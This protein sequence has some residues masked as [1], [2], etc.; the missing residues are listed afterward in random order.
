MS[1]WQWRNDGMTW[2]GRCTHEALASCFMIWFVIS[3]SIPVAQRYPF[4]VHTVPQYPYLCHSCLYPQQRIQVYLRPG[5]GRG[6]AISDHNY[7]LEL[8]GGSSCYPTQQVRTH[9]WGRP[10]STHC[11][12]KT[13]SLS[14]FL[15]QKPSTSLLSTMPLAL[16]TVTAT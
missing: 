8:Y 3:V 7:N 10:F 5:P 14:F 4:E 11:E 6:A 9:V 1:W 12:F 16:A 13:P 2:V 15:S